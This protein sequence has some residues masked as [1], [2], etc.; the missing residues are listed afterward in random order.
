MAKNGTIDLVENALRKGFSK[1]A[2][3]FFFT[4]KSD[5][6]DFVRIF[7]ISDLFRG[8]TNKERLGEIF[9][10]LE[11]NGAE[12]VIAKISLC[13]AMTKREYEREFGKDTWLGRLGD[14]YHEMKTKPKLT[15][16]SRVRNR[17]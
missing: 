10:I 8:K 15:R 11:N 3:A 5:Y 2:N 13:V 1:D 12:E 7:V 16:L 6:K 9:S 14:V 17:S 4:E